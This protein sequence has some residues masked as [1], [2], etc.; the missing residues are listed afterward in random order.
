MQRIACRSCVRY[1]RA[2]ETERVQAHIYELRQRFQ[3]WAVA[4]LNSVDP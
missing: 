3:G 4:L 1:A 2:L